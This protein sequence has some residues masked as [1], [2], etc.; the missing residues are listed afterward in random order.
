LIAPVLIRQPQSDR[1]ERRAR[2]GG[3]LNF[4]EWAAA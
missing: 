1:I 2:I 4:Y 3:M